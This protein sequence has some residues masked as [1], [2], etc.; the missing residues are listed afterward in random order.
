MYCQEMSHATQLNFVKNFGSKTF[1]ITKHVNVFTKF[2]LQFISVFYIR[3]TQIKKSQSKK[4][5]SFFPGYNYAV[6]FN[7]HFLF[8]LLSK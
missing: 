4:S 2:N 8:L 6:V 3:S 7:T 1:L 5:K